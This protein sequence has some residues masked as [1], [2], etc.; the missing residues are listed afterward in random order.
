[1][2]YYRIYIIKKQLF[3]GERKPNFRIK[4]FYLKQKGIGNNAFS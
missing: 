2:S 1:M 4:I 3:F